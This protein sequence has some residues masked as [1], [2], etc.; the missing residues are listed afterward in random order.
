MHPTVDRV[1]NR[2]KREIL[3]KFP[4]ATRWAASRRQSVRDAYHSNLPALDDRQRRHMEVLEDRGI[5]AGAWSDFGIAGVEELKPLLASLAEE[6]ASRPARP[7]GEDSTVRLS[8]DEMLEDVGLYQWGLQDEVLDLVENYLGEPARYYGP[9]VHR[10]LADSRV[11]STRQWHRDIEDERVLKILVFLNEVDTDG[12]PFTYV[13]RAITQEATRRLHY[14]GGF[15]DDERFS[16]V[17]PRSEWVQ[18]TGPQWTAAMPDTAQIFHRAQA[19]VAR[20]RYSVTFTWM[21]RTPV[22]VIGGE[23]WRPDQVARA[24]SG[25]GGRQLAALPPDVQAAVA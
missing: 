3:A 22:K 21:S 25:L 16:S 24:T 14:V 4:P 20:D 9:L 18:A 8:R 6:L 23:A 13:P 5:V 10:E 1:S 12:G 2:A 17:V 7:E 15:V 11:I 19:P